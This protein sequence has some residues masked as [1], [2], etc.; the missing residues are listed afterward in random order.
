MPKKVDSTTS[1]NSALLKCC[2][3]SLVE[4]PGVHPLGVGEILRWIAGKVVVAAT[5]NDI[6][7]NIG[8]LQI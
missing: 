4:N 2:L 7:T 8:F 6:K 5:W 1:L 3:I